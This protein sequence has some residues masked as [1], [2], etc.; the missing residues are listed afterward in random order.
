[1]H[2]TSP[3]LLSLS[4]AACSSPIG[5]TVPAGSEL[6]QIQQSFDLTSS[7]HTTFVLV[8]DDAPNASALRAALHNTLTV[9]LRDGIVSGYP[10]APHRRRDPAVAHRADLRFVVVHPSAEGDARMTGPSDDRE[11]ELVTDDASEADLDRVV[12]A[13]DRAVSSHLAAPDAPYR[14]LD[15]TKSAVTLILGARAPTTE[16]EERI[17]ETAR[18]SDSAA[19][20]VATTRDDASSGAPEQYALVG[21]ADYAVPP[22]FDTVVW[23]YGTTSGSGLSTTRVSAWETASRWLG[24]FV[25]EAL[26]VECDSPARCTNVF[27]TLFA[28]YVWPCAPS[29]LARPEGG[30]ECAVMVDRDPMFPCDGALGELDPVS[31][32][33]TRLPA[34]VTIQGE[35]FRRCEIAQVPAAEYERCHASWDY[36][37]S[38]PGFCLSTLLDR[39]YCNPNGAGWY[40]RLVGGA[41]RRE[42][43]WA[44]ITCNMQLN[45]R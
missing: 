41:N 45:P 18:G 24:S 23:A 16:R 33:G 4:I 27:D 22:Y 7:T 36:T 29:V 10:K 28:G 34:R 31:A 5:Q 25:D 8:V 17:A 39:S 37:P 35:T 20:L 2:R 38:A 3:L 43:V 14:L 13:V 30:V 11:L 26:P 40:L 9:I 44:Q 1:M 19:A 12:T 32:D 6:Q 21:P 42:N 15:A